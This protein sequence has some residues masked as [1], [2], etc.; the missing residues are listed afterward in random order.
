MPLERNYRN[1]HKF[2]AY[3]L[4][5]I[6]TVQTLH[7]GLIYAY[8]VLNKNYI[9]QNLCENKEK[10][11]LK[12]DGK[13]HLK[14]ILQV[15]QEE[16]AAP[17]QPSLPNLDQIKTPVLFFQEVKELAVTASFCYTT[18]KEEKSRFGY[19]FSYHY[20]STSAIFHPPLV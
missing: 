17:E 10:P 3:I 14:T 20:Q 12:C 2:I 1:M 13:C 16:P 18:T 19:S 4:F 11:Q 6:I 9:A 15:V 5:L 7:Q 8:Y